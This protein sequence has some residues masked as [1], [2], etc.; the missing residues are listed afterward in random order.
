[1]SPPSK[2]CLL[3]ATRVHTPNGILIGADVWLT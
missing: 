2:T 1:M 3:G